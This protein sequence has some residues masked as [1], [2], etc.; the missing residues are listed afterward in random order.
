MSRRA[1]AVAGALCRKGF[2]RTQG[3][4]AFFVYHSE[5]GVKSAVQTMISHGERELQDFLLAKMARQ[6][7]LSRADFLALVDCPLS[8]AEYESRLRTAGALP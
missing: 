2:V 7:R 4:H 1:D 3:K 5:A 6:C 8:R